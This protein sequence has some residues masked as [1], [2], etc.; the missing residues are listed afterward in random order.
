MEST[1]KPVPIEILESIYNILTTL[2]KAPEDRRQEFMEMFTSPTP[3]DTWGFEGNLG[4]AG[5]FRYDC[6][7]RNIFFVAYSFGDTN[8]E[9]IAI[10]NQ[11][12]EELAK[13]AKKL[14]A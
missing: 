10:S 8:E 3:T 2:C 13:L 6:E 14:K 7:D 1:N 4:G 5:C 12:N 9:R 11:A